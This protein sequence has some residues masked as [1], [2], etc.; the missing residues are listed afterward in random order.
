VCGHSVEEHGHDPKY[1]GSTACSECDC[2]AYEADDDDDKCTRTERDH[3]DMTPDKESGQA[4]IR[5]GKIIISVPLT[6]LQSVLDG[7]YAC[8]VYDRAYRIVDEEG[9]AKEICAA[10]NDEDED[11]TTPIHR[12]FDAAINEALNQGA[13]FIEERPTQEVG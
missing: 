3:P 1:S 6:N 11:G 4:V 13:Q 5:N 10:L 8:N 9:A 2:I 7:G 12:L